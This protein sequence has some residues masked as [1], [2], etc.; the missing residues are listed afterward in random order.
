MGVHRPVTIL[1][2]RHEQTPREL[3]NIEEGQRVHTLLMISHS[4]QLGK[5]IGHGKQVLRVLLT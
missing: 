4:M 2:E 1:P 5:V 3:M